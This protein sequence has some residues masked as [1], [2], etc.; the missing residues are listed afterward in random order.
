MPAFL[1]ASRPLLLEIGPSVGVADQAPA[2]RVVMPTGTRAGNLRRLVVGAAAA[3]AEVPAE[4]L[5]VDDGWN[6]TD[7]GY[8][9]V[10]V[11]PLAVQLPLAAGPAAVVPLGHAPAT[12]LALLLLVVARYA[13]CHAV[14]YGG[15]AY[16]L[17]DRLATTRLPAGE[18]A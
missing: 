9:V 13:V 10:T 2:A 7:A 5:L 15:R 12:A 11:P 4:V 8:R 3:L 1:M 6:G 17:R 16:P 18:P 14:L